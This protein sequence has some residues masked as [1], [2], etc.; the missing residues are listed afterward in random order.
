MTAVTDNIKTVARQAVQAMVG[1]HVEVS[2]DADLKVAGRAQPGRAVGAVV[3]VELAGPDGEPHRANRAVSA[4]G[5]A[6]AGGT[7]EV[8]S[9]ARRAAE[10]ILESN[11]GWR[12]TSG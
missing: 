9:A 2:V 7:D 12:R 8:V 4:K 10:R 5:E 3:R 6:S 1:G 11:P